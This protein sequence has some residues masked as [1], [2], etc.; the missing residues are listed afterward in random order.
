MSRISTAA[1][2]YVVLRGRLLLH[3]VKESLFVFR[4]PWPFKQSDVTRA[5]KAV[6]KLPDPSIARV[7]I[8]KDGIAIILTGG[9]PAPSDDD[10]W[11]K[12]LSNDC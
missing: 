3:V 1:R 5:L 9:A 2:L 11:D 6:L 12:A 8:T 4:G 10:D 7:E